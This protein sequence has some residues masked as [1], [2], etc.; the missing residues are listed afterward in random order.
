MTVLRVLRSR[1]TYA[2]LTA[3]LAL[4][5]ALGGGAYAAVKLPKNSVTTA[6]VRNGS[7]LSRDF[8]KGQL[9]KGARGDKGETGASG[10]QGPQ[11]PAGKDGVNGR[12]GTNGR[13]GT[14]GQNGTD[15]APGPG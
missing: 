12:D 1:L 7:L 3:T 9:P 10:A 6:Q 4:F 11:G 14:N 2:N 15:G 8:K 5:I 13:N